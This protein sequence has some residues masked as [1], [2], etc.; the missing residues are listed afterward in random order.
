MPTVRVYSRQGCHL[1]EQ[2]IEEIIPLVRDR[3]ELEILDIDTREDWRQLYGTRVPV[4]EIDGRVLCE[5][6]LDKN[7]LAA[8]IAPE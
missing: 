4:V 1:C 7:A 8:L 3:A 6:T 5:H 2:L